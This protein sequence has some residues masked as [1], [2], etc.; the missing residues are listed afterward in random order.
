M[1]KT[2]FTILLSAILLVA[3]INAKDENA[4]H[5]VKDIEP[6]IDL[7]VQELMQLDK[8]L[9]AEKRETASAIKVSEKL[10]ELHDTLL[11]K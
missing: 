7:L 4:I 9:Q 2:I 1:K 11:K 5:I 8:E 3:T 6:K 10:D